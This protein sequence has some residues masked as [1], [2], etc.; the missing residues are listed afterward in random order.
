M[1]D[2]FK[3]LYD[4]VSQKFNV[5]TYQQFVGKMQTPEERQRFYNV[6]SEKGLDLG[7]YDSYESR[8]KKKDGSD[9][10]SEPQSGPRISQ[11]ATTSEQAPVITQGEPPK[12]PSA[13]LTLPEPYLDPTLFTD[14]FVTQEK[15]AQLVADT[16][17]K[18]EQ[19]REVQKENA[20]TFLKL[21][22]SGASPDADED[23]KAK[24]AREAELKAQIGSNV[25]QVVPQHE[26]YTMSAFTTG[27]ETAQTD[28]L[29]RFYAPV[30]Q[31]TIA[32]EQD[33]ER[34]ERTLAQIEK[35]KVEDAARVYAQLDGVP[36]IPIVGRLANAGFYLLGTTEGVVDM[37]TAGQLDLNYFRDKYSTSS[38]G[39]KLNMGIAEEDLGKDFMTLIEEGKVVDAINVFATDVVNVASLSAAMSSLYGAGGMYQGAIGE[40]ERRAIISQASARGVVPGVAASV[41]MNIAQNPYLAMAT[42]LTG[43]SSGYEQTKDNPDMT[44]AEKTLYPAFSG[45]VEGLTEMGALGD[46][47]LWAGAA[48]G[49]ELEVGRKTFMD[50]FKTA[51]RQFGEA[52]IE[53]GV[54][55]EGGSYY[56]DAVW[57]YA[58]RG[59]TPSLKEATGQMLVGFVAPGPVVAMNFAS[60]VQA[61]LAMK[62]IPR[63]NMVSSEFSSRYTD[64]SKEVRSIDVEMMNPDLTKEDIA[65][66]ESAKEKAVTE[67]NFIKSRSESLYNSMNLEDLNQLATI[68]YEMNNIAGD[69]RKSNSDVAKEKM[70]ERLKELAA[71]KKDIETKYLTRDDSQAQEGVPSPVVQEEAPVAAQPV[72]V[73]S[74]EEVEA[75]GVL[76]VPSQEEAAV[77][78]PVVEEEEVSVPVEQALPEIAPEVAQDVADAVVFTNGKQAAGKISKSGA[79]LVERSLKVLSKV[80]PSIKI[81]AHKNKASLLKSHQDVTQ[82]TEGYYNAAEN[83]IHILAEDLKRGISDNESRVLRHE[84]IHPILSAEIASD[85]RLAARFSK[86]I[87]AIVNQPAIRDS[88][89]SEKVRQTFQRFGE[90]E[91]ITEFLAQ[92]TTPEAFSQIETNPTL[93]QRVKKFLNDLIKRVFPNTK[94]RI[95]TG[96]EALEFLTRLNDSI[97][98]G[99]AFETAS[100]T[101]QGAVV[102]AIQKSTDFELF[103]DD[104]T[105]DDF[106]V[107]GFL[108]LDDII[109]FN[110]EGLPEGVGQEV[111]DMIPSLNALSER[112][113]IPYLLVDLPNE[114]FVAR[115]GT[116]RDAGLN[117]VSLEQEFMNIE[118]VRDVLSQNNY[119]AQ[120]A[121][122][123]DYFVIINASTNNPSSSIGTFAA[124][125][126]N[127]I[128]TTTGYR[129]LVKR[130]TGKQIEGPKNFEELFVSNIQSYRAAMDDMFGE[131]LPAEDKLVKAVVAGVSDILKIQS[132]YDPGSSQY[133]QIQNIEVIS[134]LSDAVLDIANE[135]VQN[136]PYYIDNVDL[137]GSMSALAHFIASRNSVTPR[138]EIRDVNF[139]T[140]VAYAQEL[141]D[142]LVDG[143]AKAMKELES[144]VEF[145]QEIEDLGEDAFGT[146]EMMKLLPAETAAIVADIKLPKAFNP[147]YIDLTD[148]TVDTG[149]MEEVQERFKFLAEFYADIQIVGGEFETLRIMREILGG[150]KS[151]EKDLIIEFAAFTRPELGDISKLDESFWGRIHFDFY[152][153]LKGSVVD[154]LGGDFYRL[155]YMGPS[156]R[157]YPKKD[158][159]GSTGLNQ[160]LKPYSSDP[161]V[162]S[163]SL[164][165]SIADRVLIPAGN[166]VEFMKA[167]ERG[168][169][170]YIKKLRSGISQAKTVEQVVRLIGR[171][172]EELEKKYG[173]FLRPI[174]AKKNERYP[175]EY[176][177]SFKVPAVWQFPDA[178]EASG[179][180]VR[181]AYRGKRVDD[182]YTVN[183]I[184]DPIKKSVTVDFNTKLFGF[185]NVPQYLN[186]NQYFEKIMNV[187]P[188]SF[189]DRDIDYVTFA[190][191][192]ED[193]LEG[194][195]P[196]TSERMRPGSERR[197]LLYNFAYA[198][199]YDTAFDF[200]SR[201]DL[202]MKVRGVGVFALPVRSKDNKG[203]FNLKQELSDLEDNFSGND[204]IEK[205]KEL[206][207]SYGARQIETGYDL[208]KKGGLNPGQEQIVNE[209]VESYNR[210]SKFGEQLPYPRVYNPAVPLSFFTTSRSI[211][212]SKRIF[213]DESKFKPLKKSSIKALEVV[214]ES[215]EALA[216]AADRNKKQFSDLLKKELWWDRAATVRKAMRDGQL[217]YVEAVMD[218]KAGSIANANKEFAAIEDAIY[219]KLSTGD[220]EL[221]DAIIY[222]KRVIQVDTNFDVRRATI[223]TELKKNEGA[224]KRFNEV[225]ENVRDKKTRSEIIEKI[226]TLEKTIEDQKKRR[227][228]KARPFHAKPSGF[229]GRYNKEAAL[230]DLDQMV[231]EYGRGK[232]D[233]VSAKANEYFDYFNNIWLRHY[234]A[235]L[236]SLDEYNRFRNDDYAPRIFLRSIIEE[237][238]S[239]VEEVMPKGLKESQ[240]RAITSGSEALILTDSRVLLSMGIKSLSFRR[241][242]NAA[243]KALAED[244]LTVENKDWIREANYKLNKDGDIEQ[245]A[246][247]NYNVAKPDEGFK[248]M[249]YRDGGKLRAV[250]MREEEYIEFNDLRKSYFNIGADLRSAIRKYSGSNVLRAFATGISPVFAVMNAPAELGS[251]LLGRGVYDG[252]RFLPVATAKL[253]FDYARGLWNASRGYKSELLREAF[254]HGIGMTFLSNEGRPE[255]AA[256]RK[257][258]GT[259][260]FLKSRGERTLFTL[261][262]LGE[263]TEIGLRLAV[264]SQAKENFKAKYPEYSDDRIKYL[265]AAEARRITDFAQGGTLIKDL[266]SP[267]PYLNAAAQGFRANASYVKANKAAFLSKLVQA[268]L[269]V[270]ALAMYNVMSGD[271]D[272][273]DK[274]PPYIKQ[275]YFIVFTPFFD[276][277]GFRKYVRI[278]KPQTFTG[279]LMAFEMIGQ[280]L[281]SYIKDG[282][283]KEFT[284]QDMQT[285]YDSFIDA[286]PFFIPFLD[287]FAALG[288]RSPILSASLKTFGNYDAFRKQLVVPEQG[289][290]SVYMEGY[291]NP[292]IE[293]FYKAIGAATSELPESLQ[294]SPAKSK[295]VI[296]TFITSP[297]N[298]VVTNLAYQIMDVITSGIKVED[299][300]AQENSVKDA[301]TNLLGNVKGAAVRSA[302]PNWQKYQKYGEVKKIQL[303]EADL[304]KKIVVQLKELSKPYRGKSIKRAP[305]EVVDYIESLDASRRRSAAR[306]FFRFVAASDA[307]AM[308]YN[309]RF[310]DTPQES[311]R[312]FLYYFGT[313]QSGT[314]EY[315][316]V[317]TGLEKVGFVPSYD[318]R[319]ALSEEIKKQKK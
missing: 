224:L 120:L 24:K 33:R 297:T 15:R 163:P 169:A 57:Q 255:L 317:M 182:E 214:K 81:I 133:S 66:L 259:L 244:A 58:V 80:N 71:T 257:Y 303:E 292:K 313:P 302:D 235:G 196:T 97:Q 285:A 299:P 314:E 267:L 13:G 154:A 108:P 215:E 269:G 281:A 179:Y 68:H 142:Q 197:A 47:R 9:S 156:I 164:P 284:E 254:E 155:S 64:L 226:A 193:H 162:I 277:N 28:I 294:V 17:K 158:K 311:A 216:K 208:T 228:E 282:K 136:T 276:E 279:P 219:S 22:E 70:K 245:D 117:V 272:D 3:S 137:A 37:L 44:L 238:S 121:D 118:A 30:A 116:I 31:Q 240:I 201:E 123:Q 102:D 113:G 213:I 250:Q 55:E 139:P 127:T 56:A 54:L 132:G 185:S 45:L 93:F 41:R 251:V 191:A 274:I 34:M 203:Y 27:Q 300:T 6:V 190:A 138:Y 84:I 253:A 157:N 135:G 237:E 225:L 75:G 223:D 89:E 280:S 11:P 266:D 90:V 7:D 114:S 200:R 143:E 218:D 296:E 275:R 283:G 129:N 146:G 16:E 262:W 174:G 220:I 104:F 78:T 293:R 40:A 160:V 131:D 199:Q 205:S 51:L 73:P 63:L 319:L 289:D 23:F 61:N 290:V 308:F 29:N 177:V 273:L 234:E 249:F 2:D 35:D 247:G 4:A 171:T 170:D 130:V 10:A 298:S 295:A 92:F 270:M 115:V 72:E 77:E 173:I 91:G 107:S 222:A 202:A 125:F 231:A 25:A 183:A 256:K 168:V 165:D 152:S 211:D 236:I 48:T 265:A 106:G 19:L 184:Y 65:V 258:Q 181:K 210:E 232:F 43:A 94:Y 60:E 187:I 180:K 227:A 263:M 8:L 88:F 192:T 167:Q 52:G 176:T 175:D 85:P 204:L 242:E 264:Y 38:Q 67:L 230:E 166:M 315:R 301:A 149:V 83:T 86:Q 198:R 119:P 252:Y 59:T 316:E 221:L 268:G 100:T 105:E 103:E 53:E 188:Y 109:S 134:A 217:E 291:G 288:N 159:K 260:E 189:L 124:Y 150:P 112:F 209:V 95:E 151:P 49:A 286:F 153:D 21:K 79:E 141:A 229:E 18:R 172:N 111:I 195:E 309:V 261:S 74:T 69:Y 46:I 39:L 178:D 243:N 194:F 206:V 241:F 101:Q 76:Q 87:D 14:K 312:L 233:Q 147:F 287:E 5:G 207:A 36:S 248:N 82:E 145:Y 186:P 32:I 12:Q 144:Y 318:F 212:E 305:D 310:A 246:Y 50:S 148:T 161:N 110:E 20:Q 239:Y 26:Q 126:V 307:E 99:K 278:K 271:D 42:Y 128:K 96:Q 140:A 122:G 1:E 62:R 304:D 98:K 306:K